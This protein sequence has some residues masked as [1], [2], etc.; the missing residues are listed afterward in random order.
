MAAVVFAIFGFACLL[1][2][3]V[4]LPGTWVLLGLA[5]LLELGDAVYLSADEPMTFGWTLLAA[6][7]GIGLV[8]EVLEV[9]VGAAGASWGGATRRGVIGSFLCAIVGAIAFTP[10]IPIPIVGTLLGALLGTFL[11]ALIGEM[12]AE[13]QRHPEENLRAALAAAAGRIAGTLGK[14]GFGI[15]IWILL[16]R[17]AFL[18]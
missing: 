3:P 12:T 10:V 4:G 2:I 17:A 6:C 15:A 8:G 16:V 9:A 18:E 1:A 11:G 14:L 13:E 7:A 5:A